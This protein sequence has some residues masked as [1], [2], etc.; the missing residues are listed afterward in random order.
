[1]MRGTAVVLLMLGLITPSE[2]MAQWLEFDVPDRPEA[3]S[4]FVEA[5]REV[6][7]THCWYCHGDE[8]DGLGP[9]AEY[10]WPRPRDFTIASF[11]LRTTPSG[12]LPTDED[13]YR[14]ISLGLPGT[15]MPAWRSVLTV[16]E[17]WQVVAY[18]KSFGDGMFEDEAF[19]PY[20]TVIDIGEPPPGSVESLVEA[21]RSVFQDSDC[22]ECHGDAGRGDGP[23]SSDLRDDW[24][25]PIRATDLE[26]GWKF[27]GGSTPEETYVRLTTGL[28]GTPMPSY[29]ETLTDDERWQVAYYVSSLEQNV[30]GGGTRPVVITAKR[31]DGPIPVGS[32]DEA[33][34]TAEP[35][36][37]PLTGQATYAPRWQNPSI[38]DLAVQAMYNKQEIAL[39]VRW[40]DRTADSIHV[41]A[42][43]ATE[44]G[45]T[46]DDT[47]P[48]IYPSG[49]RQRG[50]YR[51]VLEILFPASNRGPVLPHFVYGDSR[52]P[53][54]LWRWTAGVHQEKAIGSVQ[55]LRAGGPSQRPQLQPADSQL[56]TGMAEW[57]DGRWTVI[58]R[59]P[60]GAELPFQPGGL[61][62]IS[63]H[64]RDGAH[65]ETGLR[66]SLS[67]WYFLHLKEPAGSTEVLL[68][69]LAIVG[70]AV[71]EFAVV[72]HMRRRAREGRLQAFGLGSTA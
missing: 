5:G 68:V 51:D 25:Y 37:I 28:D 7:D 42:G 35:I 34:L 62:P 21:G 66:M 9:V 53:V 60:L 32:S 6:Y 36:W 33:W 19:D 50:S 63:F 14:S 39:R 57:I 18:L 29:S 41:D 58:L 38:T 20:D 1:M 40:N 65:G 23:K 56:A 11:K 12:E 55:V 47:Y 22:W 10:V 52:R 64:A 72:R 27:R 8:G 67:S 15:A 44:E 24:S 48:V 16:T 43:Q 59:R 71:V 26:L 69:L 45:W 54:D 30:A 70:T 31:V 17:R 49:E 46:A 3:G 13:L 61:V 2:A 4:S